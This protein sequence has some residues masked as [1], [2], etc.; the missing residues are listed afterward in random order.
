MKTTVID[1]RCATGI[2][3]FDK[4][5][6]GGFLPQSINLITGGP[7][8]G[9]TT[10]VLEWL[11]NGLTK[12]NENG[13]FV[14][15]EDDLENVKKDALAH[16]WDFSKHENERRFNFS[17]IIPYE[18]GLSLEMQKSQLKKDLL[19]SIKKFNIKRIV[20]DPITLFGMAFRTSY[21]IRKNLFELVQMLKSIGCVVLITSETAGEA[22]LDIS[23]G[24]SYSRFGIEEFIADSVVVLHNSG[25]GGETD[26]ALRIIKMRRTD[27][28][29][30]PIPMA[31]KKDG[32]YLVEE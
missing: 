16:G 11:W 22:P 1:E 32:I 15:F 13:M 28:V 18:Q 23:A 10:F 27:H 25:L 8:S 5:T 4:I 31:I 2:P 26:R 12:Y 30:G 19:A 3:V 7:G 9:K 6:K 17:S 20:I 24:G 29:R 14:S 21:E